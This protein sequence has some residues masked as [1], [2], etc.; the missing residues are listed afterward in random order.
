MPANPR[1]PPPAS[2]VYAPAAGAVSSRRV[3]SQRCRFLLQAWTVE[4]DSPPRSRVEAKRTELR[5]SQPAQRDRAKVLAMLPKAA[6]AYLKQVDAFAA[7]SVGNLPNKVAHQ[8]RGDSGACT[9]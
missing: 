1:G 9:H 8:N 5:A 2:S 6:A 4:R 3:S 7:E